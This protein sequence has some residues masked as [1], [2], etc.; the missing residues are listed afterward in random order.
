MTT[1]G[2][3]PPKLR[4]SSAREDTIRT[5]A[6]FLAAAFRIWALDQPLEQFASEVEQVERDACAQES[7]LWCTIADLAL[8]AWQATEAA[9]LRRKPN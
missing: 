2:A 7:E 3:D 1:P 9:E 6:V 4:E 5:V 8:A